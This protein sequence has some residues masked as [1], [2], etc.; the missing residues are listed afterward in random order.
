MR[1]IMEMTD[2]QVAWVKAEATRLGISETEVI[3]RLI[4]KAMGEK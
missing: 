3:R 2:R 4:D 1:K